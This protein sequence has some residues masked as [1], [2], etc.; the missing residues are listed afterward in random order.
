M[1]TEQ[2]IS[3]IK[4]KLG[5]QCRYDK[6][7][8]QLYLHIKPHTE[9]NFNTE[10]IGNV[11]QTN[12]GAI[13]QHMHH[14]NKKSILITKHINKNLAAKLQDANIEYIDFSGNMFINTD[15]VYIS[16]KGE[17]SQKSKQLETRSFTLS[18]ASIKIIFTLLTIKNALNHNYRD[19]AKMSNVALGSVS[20]TFSILE[21]YGYVTEKNH[22]KKYLL[23]KE[24]LLSKW[25]IGY[26]EKVRPKLMI[27]K[28]NSNNVDELKE[29]NSIDYNFLWGGEIAAAKLTKYLKPEIITLYADNELPLLQYKYQLKKNINGNIELIKK[30]WNFDTE[31]YKHH[32]VPYIL[33]YA[34]LLNSSDERNQETAEIIYDQFIKKQM[35]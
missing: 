6:K 33:I 13:I 31:G 32:V 7:I 8:N 16:I 2:L 19:I 22:T 28:F 35:E 18:V 14:L 23:N 11:D 30:F 20:K 29:T 12:V 5:F 26:N 9:L 1:N 10:M 34:D 3:N 21:Q 4:D 25:C 15:P 24:N 27:E 17:A